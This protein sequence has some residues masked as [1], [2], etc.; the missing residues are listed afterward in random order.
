[1]PTRGRLPADRGKVG[2]AS[3]GTKV[4]VQAEGMAE[5]GKSPGG[6]NT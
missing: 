3:G 5:E 2:G 6:T 1:M 4:R